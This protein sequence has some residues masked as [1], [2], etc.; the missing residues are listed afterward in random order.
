MVIYPYTSWYIS[1]VKKV[2]KVLSSEKCNIQLSVFCKIYTATNITAIA[3]IHF[4]RCIYRMQQY[5]RQTSL[6]PL[7]CTY[8]EK[9]LV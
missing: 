8:L 1:L 5:G 9:C 3:T 7:L 4:T 6:M 2:Q